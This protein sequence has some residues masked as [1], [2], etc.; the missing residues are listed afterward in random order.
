MEIRLPLITLTLLA[1]TGCVTSTGIV[2]I[3][4][5]TYLLSKQDRIAWSGSEVKIELYQEANAYCASSGKKLVPVAN[6]S[7]DASYMAIA[8]AEL[9]FKCM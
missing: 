5:D 4:D 2:K 1:L 6:T 8:G 3:T 9:Q 7:V